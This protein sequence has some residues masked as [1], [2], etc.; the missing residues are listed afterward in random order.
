MSRSRVI[1]HVCCLLALACAAPVRAQSSDGAL[2]DRVGQ[3]LE[4]L[5]SK[6]EQKANEAEQALIE[7]GPKVLPLLPEDKK[8]PDRDKRIDRIREKLREAQDAAA[9]TASVI[10]LKRQGMR[11]SEAL[12]EFQKQS[13]NAISDIRDQDGGEPENP[14]ISLDLS[15]KPFLEALDVISEHADV[16]FNFYTGDG[17]VGLMAG[18]TS[19]DQVQ[20]LLRTVSD[21]VEARGVSAR[22]SRRRKTR[23]GKSPVRARL[24]TQGPADAPGP[25]G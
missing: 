9:I 22:F 3:L 2:K 11:L 6:T 21:G 8:S 19:E 20:E 5:E 15:N 12:R 7:L 4:R 18:A 13:G 16:Q 10:T 23:R 14:T 17:T 25:E 1:V 24:G